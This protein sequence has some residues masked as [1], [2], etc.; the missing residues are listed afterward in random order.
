MRQQLTLEP[1]LTLVT[2]GPGSVRSPTTT[3]SWGPGGNAPN[4]C[5]LM[6]S[7]RIDL[8]TSWSGWWLALVLMLTSWDWVGTGSRLANVCRSTGGSRTRARVC[9]QRAFAAGAD[10]AGAPAGRRITTGTGR[11]AKE[12]LLDDRAQCGGPSTSG[13]PASTEAR[14]A[15]EQ[16][17]RACQAR[18]WLTSGCGVLTADRSEPSCGRVVVAAER[19]SSRVVVKWLAFAARCR[20]SLR[21]GS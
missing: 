6:S 3:E 12:E 8:K 9:H 11:A 4:G 1:T 2:Y 16:G 21:S 14:F 13:R 17:P 18:V 15:G 20:R 10:L 7:D 19:M 5:Q